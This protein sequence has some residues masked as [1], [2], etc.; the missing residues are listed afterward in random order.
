MRQVTN[1]ATFTWE[2]SFVCSVNETL[3]VAVRAQARSHE[4]CDARMFPRLYY[5]GCDVGGLRK[6]SSAASVSVTAAD[7][8]PRR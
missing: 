1:K 7:V 6:S 2:P 3:A 8:S 4:G 5:F